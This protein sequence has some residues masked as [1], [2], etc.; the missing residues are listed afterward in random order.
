MENLISFPNLGIDL[1]FKET[2]FKLFGRSIYWYAIIMTVSIILG[3][4]YVMLR[5]K[6]EGISSDDVIDYA[7][8]GIILGI[9]G[10][11]LYYVLTSLDRYKDFWS[12]FK[13]WEGG[14]AFYGSL[15]GGA[16]AV[17]LVSR[18]KKQS[19]LKLFDLI[20]P[21]MMLGQI[22]GRWGNFIN[23][24]AYGSVE[25]YEFFG[26]VFN[27]NG[28]KNLPWV[29]TVNGEYAQP[30]FLYESLWN[31]VG[32]ILINIFY[33]KKKFN[34]QIFAAYMA[35]YGFGRMFIEGMRTDSLYVGPIKI[36]QLLGAIFFIGGTALFFT[37]KKFLKLDPK[38]AP[39]EA[40]KES[41][42]VVTVEEKK[43]DEAEKETEDAADRAEEEKETN[44]KPEDDT[45]EK[46]EEI[47][48]EKPDGEPEE[49]PSEED[50]TAADSGADPEETEEK[51]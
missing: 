48:E 23:G 15:I 30:T 34:G 11:R 47:T 51:A 1:T 7:I 45:E 44:E 21:A 8:F 28:A 20:S 38:P 50:E 42:D 39:A 31:L 16:L 43:P 41:A 19:T 6:F 32:F 24:E 22:I 26:K 18:R 17:F 36:S 4:V 12:V 9:V 13:I 33:K 2:A 35:W 25:Q 49:K 10:A 29:M 37:G 5:R 3:V 46:P 27:V 40:E 14:L